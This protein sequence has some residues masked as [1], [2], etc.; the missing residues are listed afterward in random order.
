MAEELS[1]LIAALRMARNH[2]LSQSQS[3]KF[4]NSKGF[5]VTLDTLQNWEIGHR[6]PSSMASRT[7]SQYLQKH[8][9]IKAPAR[10]REKQ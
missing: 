9:K 1:P 2:H 10:K 7:L 4:F 8:P 3:V 5:P 6:S